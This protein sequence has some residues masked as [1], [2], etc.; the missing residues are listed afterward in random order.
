MRLTMKP[1]PEFL[2]EEADRQFSAKGNQLNL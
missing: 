2:A 1:I